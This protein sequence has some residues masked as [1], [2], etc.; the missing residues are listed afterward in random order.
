MCCAVFIGCTTA[1]TRCH[2][3]QFVVTRCITCC[4]SFSLVA[5]IVIRCHSLPLVVP[6]IVILC[7]S[8]S[9]VRFV[10]IRC[11]SLYHS[12]SLDVPLVCLFINN[13]FNAIYFVIF[14]NR[15][16]VISPAVQDKES[17]SRA[18][19]RRRNKKDGIISEEDVYCKNEHDKENKVDDEIYDIIYELILE[20]K[21]RKKRQQKR[22]LKLF[23]IIDNLPITSESE[24]S[25]LVNKAQ[26][27]SKVNLSNIPSVGL[28]FRP[29]NVISKE[30]GNQ[31]KHPYQSAIGEPIE[32]RPNFL[33]QVAN[34]TG[35]MLHF[36]SGIPDP[37]KLNSNV[38]SKQSIEKEN[39]SFD[40][41]K[42]IMPKFLHPDKVKDDPL[43]WKNILKLTRNDSKHTQT[44]TYKT[45][46]H[47]T[48]VQTEIQEMV[49]I[50]KTQTF[51]TEPDIKQTNEFCER[52][53]SE[54]IEK[55]DINK[56]VLENKGCQ[57]VSD[58]KTQTK[59]S[60][61]PGRIDSEE[62]FLEEEQNIQMKR[63]EKEGEQ[64]I[65]SSSCVI[66][67]DYI[68]TSMGGVFR[69][70][71]KIYDGAFLQK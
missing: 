68:S 65:V 33:K 26:Q 60:N 71:S 3:L 15:T 6:L 32:Q 28:S 13:S 55:L 37:P 23:D 67:T 9:L 47:E 34:Y 48:E 57:T 59:P 10:A 12:L 50:P 17:K 51:F 43:S 30:N 56:K 44:E 27:K 39:S 21:K 5:P 49:E 14:L 16:T 41:Y 40:Q 61:S 42:P 7:H 11:H 19:R 52:V 20:K 70:L 62:H 63:N 53:R 66:K 64:I 24:E 25:P 35:D 31:N 36:D 46:T 22:K 8:F 58:A 38:N 1:V 29:S 54:I 69:T 2:S 18:R 4:H 45:K